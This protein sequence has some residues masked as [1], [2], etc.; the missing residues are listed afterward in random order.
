MDEGI[1][2][3]VPYQQ[4]PPRYEYLLTDKGRD[5]FPVLA[6]IGAWG[7]RWLAPDEGPPVVLRHQTCG[8]ESRALVVCDKCGEQLRLDEVSSRLGPGFPRRHRAAA[9]ASGRFASEPAD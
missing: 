8:H 7:D 9:L 4:R 6:A 1:L 5:I 3:R 2:E